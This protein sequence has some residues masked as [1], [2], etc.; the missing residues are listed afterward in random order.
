M[1]LFPEFNI[2]FSEFDQVLT[3]LPMEDVR[4]NPKNKGDLYSLTGHFK[5]KAGDKIHPEGTML[6][7]ELMASLREI[8][9]TEELTLMINAIDFTCA[10]QRELMK[11]L[12]PGMNEYEAEAL[13]EYVF[14]KNGAEH[15]GFPS[16]LGGGENACILHYV[17]NRRELQEGDLLVSDIGAEYHNYTAD[18]TRTLPV[19]GKFTEEQK[20]IYNIVLEAQQAGINVCKEGNKFRDPANEAQRVVTEG[21]IRLGIIEKPDEMKRY[22]MHGTS[23]Y[24][25]LDVHDAGLYGPLEKGNVITVEP[26]I[27][28]AE[29]SP[30]DL[31]GGTLGY[32]LKTTYSLPMVFPKCFRAAC[33]KPSM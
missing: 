4:D 31:N 23:H 1:L 22:F 15:P 27:Y 13:I 18:V 26:G 32:V 9:Q 25:G 7:Q 11:A 3:I 5:E 19:S 30:C 16:I 28:I 14:M 8:K 21:L 20:A 33:L 2:D 6:L 29:G 17:S 24:L 10:A 12:E